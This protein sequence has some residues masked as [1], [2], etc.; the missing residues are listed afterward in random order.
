MEI[1]NTYI[2]KWEDLRFSDNYIFCKVM[3]NE[4]LCKE[5]I[6]ILLH[7]KVEK[8]ERNQT[9]KTF[10]TGITQRGIRMDVFVKDSDRVFDIEMQTCNYSDLPLRS[11]YYQSVIDVSTVKRREQFRGLNEVYI[12][13][14]CLNDPFNKGLP[15]YTVKN[16]VEEDFSINYNDKSIKVF[17]N[18]KAYRDVLDIEL[19]GFLEYVSEA[20]VTTSFSEKIESLVSENKENSNWEEGYMLFSEYLEEFRYEVTTVVKEETKLEE[21]VKT[22]KRMLQK[23]NYSLEDIVEITELSLDKVTELQKELV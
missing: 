16:K 5:L 22:A 11:R 10:E 13:F 19:R 4:E 8:I 15:V 18:A 3:E 17:F 2:K 14:I 23:G 12:I 21:Q 20:H 6:E 9:E 1:N 7:I